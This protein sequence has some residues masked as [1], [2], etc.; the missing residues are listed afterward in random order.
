MNHFNIT[1]LRTGF[2]MQREVDSYADDISR[3]AHARGVEFGQK[4]GEQAIDRALGIGV[5]FGTAFGV[6]MTLLAQ[7]WL[8]P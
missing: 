8:L 5:C 2:Q 6:L 3:A 7:G 4:L 1:P